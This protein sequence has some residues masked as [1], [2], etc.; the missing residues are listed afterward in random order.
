MNTFTSQL[1]QLSLQGNLRH[2]PEME[3]N[4]AYV[5]IKGMKMLNLSSNDYLGLADDT[6]L[7]DEFLQ[8]VDMRER[9]FSSTSSRLLTGNGVLY[10][11][12]ENRL[13]ELYGA[14]SALV[15]NSGYH[16]LLG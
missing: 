8:T 9:R 1:Q 11:Q 16:A 14:E 4:G 5:F 2:L 3:E 12:L 15:F 6:V 7:R 13:A 10:R